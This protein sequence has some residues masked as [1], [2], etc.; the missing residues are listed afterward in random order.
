M[1]L[2]RIVLP[3][4]IQTPW[5]QNNRIP[6]LLSVPEGSPRAGIVA[7]HGY[8]GGKETLSEEIQ[9][10]TQSGYAVLAPDL[11]LHGER[12]LGEDALF[13]Y[14]FYGDPMG[15]SKSFENALADIEVCARAL[16]DRLGDQLPLGVTGYSMGGCLTILAK[17]RLPHLFR[18]G[19]S[20][21]GSALVARLILTSS[22][23]PDIA[24]DLRRMGYEEQNYAPLVR[25]VE[26]TAYADQITNLML[27]GG[28]EDDI[29]PGILVRETYARLKGDTNECVMFEGIGHFPPIEQYGAYA[30]DFFARHF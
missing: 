21:V 3:A 19:V 6:A 14:P 4:P 27:M 26:A 24:D 11:P 15:I 28:E 8:T 1:N 20:I 30:L 18:A 13:V 7:L 17:A 25:Q 10:L 2:E 23:T 29:V 16:R 12:A 9:G 5:A 22:I